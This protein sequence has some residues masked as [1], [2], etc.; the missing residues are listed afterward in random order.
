MENNVVFTISQLLS[1]YKNLL[2]VVKIFTLEPNTLTVRLLWGLL[3]VIF[4]STFPGVFAVSNGCPYSY[5]SFIL[6]FYFS[7]DCCCL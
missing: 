7:V 3:M 2:K 4:Y 6:P 5:N 1:P